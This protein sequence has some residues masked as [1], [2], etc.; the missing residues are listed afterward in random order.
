MTCMS[1]GSGDTQLRQSIFNRGGDKK[2][3]TVLLRQHTF[4]DAMIKKGEERCVESGGVE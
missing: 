3:V 2:D 1:R 4:T